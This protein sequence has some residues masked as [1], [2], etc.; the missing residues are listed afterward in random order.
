[1]NKIYILGV[2]PQSEDVADSV[3]KFVDNCILYWE[4]IHWTE[5]KWQD[6]HYKCIHMHTST[7]NK[8]SR[9]ILSEIRQALEPRHHK[10]SIIVTQAAHSTASVTNNSDLKWLHFRMYLTVYWRKVYEVCRPTRFT[11]FS[12]SITMRIWSIVSRKKIACWPKLFVSAL[13]AWLN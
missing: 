1:M 9:L 7:K 11:T 12:Q 8:Q 4:V 13:N 2:S 5:I 6:I 3:D 10:A